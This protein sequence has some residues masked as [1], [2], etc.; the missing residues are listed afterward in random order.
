MSSAHVVSGNRPPV[1]RPNQIYRPGGSPP[2]SAPVS[3]E[4][5]REEG[6]LLCLVCCHPA[7]TKRVPEGEGRK[8]RKTKMA[9]GSRCTAG[10]RSGGGA[11]LAASTGGHF[12]Q[13]WQALR[14]RQAIGW[15]QFQISVLGLQYCIAR[16][17]PYESIK[18]IYGTHISISIVTAKKS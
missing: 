6:G 12:R 11:K 14:M 13:K 17:A 1:G 8:W 3:G 16:L 18:Y 2:R 7:R 4:R 9:C 10:G 15:N 5:R